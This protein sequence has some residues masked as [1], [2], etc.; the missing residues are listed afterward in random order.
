VIGRSDPA[1]TGETLVIISQVYPPDP[2]AVGQHIAD[3]AGHFARR[4]WRVIVFTA[5][6][7]YDDPAVRYPARESRDGVTIRRLRWSSFG[8]RSLL[9]RL[10]AQ[11]LFMTQAVCRS[12]F[13]PRLTAVLVSTSPPFAGAGGAVAATMRRVPFVW[14]VMDVNPDQFVSARK[15][16]SRSVLVRM[17]DCLNRFTL[18]HAR[19]VIVLD[20]FM[21]QRIHAKLPARLPPVIVPPWSHVPA[22]ADAA[23]DA[24]AFRRQHAL[25]DRFL[26]VYAGN[27]ALQHPLDTLLDA[28]AMMTSSDVTF[29]FVGGGAGKAAIDRVC[30]AGAPNIVSLPYQPLES[31][32]GVLAAADLHVVSMGND[33]VGISHPC[34]IYGVMAAG[35]PVL[36]LGPQSSHCGEL[37]NRAECGWVVAHGDMP[38]VIAAIAEA[39]AMGCDARAAMGAR[40]AEVIRRD[41]SADATIRRISD[42]VEASHD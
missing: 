42:I 3:V 36:Y 27:H 11:G 37:V 13:V 38:A 21:Q 24:V 32:A 17:F 10:V 20:R 16:N 9:V 22:G 4:G 14:W 6:R 34:K 8:K 23:G 29:V 18:K 35:R 30:N 33:T 25:G 26:V 2:A 15:A 19:E 40:G 5:N 7:G 31:L 1:S 12:L 28:A 41:Y 39:R